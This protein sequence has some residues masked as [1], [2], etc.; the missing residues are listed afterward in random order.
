MFDLKKAV[1]NSVEAKFD[2]L[3]NDV[4]EQNKSAISMWGNLDKCIKLSLEL[5]VPTYKWSPRDKPWSMEHA[6]DLFKTL[7]NK[8]K[9]VYQKIKPEPYSYNIERE[10]GLSRQ[11]KIEIR[12]LKSVFLSD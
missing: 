2:E 3:F 8:N 11:V 4:I 1:Y 6:P 10:K 12:K 7:I 9:R 5:Y